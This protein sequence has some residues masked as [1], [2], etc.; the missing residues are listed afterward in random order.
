MTLVILL[1]FSFYSSAG[2]SDYAV[3]QKVCE[4]TYKKNSKNICLCVKNNL[5]KKLSGRQ[6]KSLARIYRDS[7]SRI[8][9]S[10]DATK[11]S[12][13]A[14]D[15]EVHRNCSLNPDWQWLPEDLGAPD[16]LD[17]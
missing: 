11:K 14:H 15:Y 6:L 17:D 8:V 2:T 13:L 4:K 12:I 5:R 1:F 3:I 7:S 9:A 16:S 10:K